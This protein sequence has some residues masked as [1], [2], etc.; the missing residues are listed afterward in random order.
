[1]RTSL[2][3]LTIILLM[4]AISIANDTSETGNKIQEITKVKLESKIIDFTKSEK[5]LL[6]F[7]ITKDA[8]VS[9]TFYNELGQEVQ[10]LKIP[11]A[12][13][14]PHSIE[15]DGKDA[16]GKPVAGKVVLY[17]IE[18]V[19]A[20]GRKTTYSPAKRTGGLEVKASDYSF[21]AKTGKIEY[22]LPKT[23]MVRIRA[24][25]KDAVLVRTILDWEPQTAGRHILTWDGKDEGGLV[26]IGSHPDLELNLACYTLPANTIIVSGQVIPLPESGQGGKFEKALWAREGKYLHYSHD[27][28]NCHEPKFTISFPQHKKTNEEGLPILSGKVPIRIEVD[29]NDI[30]Y[31]TNKRFEIVFYIDG[32]FLFEMEEGTSPFTCHWDTKGFSKGPHTMTVNLIS[33]DDHIGVL[34]KKII[35]GDE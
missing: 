31:M 26:D 10:Q 32:V 20:D 17:V 21:Y 7:E 14:G 28:R 13:A 22:V 34:N 18:A 1:M 25:L 23:C 11:A 6:S 5:A 8:D 3:E 16:Q 15:W 9:V 27:P 4:C 35:V 2:I 12:K 19:N 30:R 29:P 33:Y 24:G